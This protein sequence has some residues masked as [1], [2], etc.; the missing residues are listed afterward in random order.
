MGKKYKFPNINGGKE[1]EMPRIT[2]GD[3]E[4]MFR[5]Q[6]EIEIKASNE[7]NELLYGSTVGMRV[8]AERILK[9]IDDKIIVS[10]LPAE[11]YIDF[12]EALQNEHPKLFKRGDTVNFPNPFKNI[13]PET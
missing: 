10:D 6:A 11:E 8:L 9:K 13:L 5:A 3:L 2:Q 12:I 4:A 1:F 7:M